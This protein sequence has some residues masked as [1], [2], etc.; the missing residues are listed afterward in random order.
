MDSPIPSRSE[1]RALE[2]ILGKV[3]P[4]LKQILLRHRIP[5]RDAESLL[6]EILFVLVEKWDSIRNPEAWLKATLAHRCALYWRRLRSH[7]W[8]QIDRAILELIAG[9]T[10]P[11]EQRGQL[12]DSVEG[13][14]SELPDPCRSLLR[15][16][17]GLE[18]PA[19]GDERTELR[20]GPGKDIRDCLAALVDRLLLTRV[21]SEI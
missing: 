12:R 18:G 3:E 11:P 2:D 15:L 14:L 19:E 17:Y 8:S 13:L 7:V 4:E 21:L 20:T 16:H 6:Q 5:P 9:P 1:E 10:S